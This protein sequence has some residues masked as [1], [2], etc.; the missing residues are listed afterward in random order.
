MDKRTIGKPSTWFTRSV[1]S[2]DPDVGV[3]LDV[4]RRAQARQDCRRQTCNLAEFLELEEPF[5]EK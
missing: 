1:I 5:F 3:D 2:K 4:S